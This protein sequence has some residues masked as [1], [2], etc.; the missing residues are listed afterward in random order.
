MKV[1]NENYVAKPFT[2]TNL[3]AAAAPPPSQVEEL[4]PPTP[5]PKPKQQPQ[6]WKHAMRTKRASRKTSEKLAKLRLRSL[7]AR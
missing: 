5:K 2:P 3:Y 6:N 4:P 7:E 1:A